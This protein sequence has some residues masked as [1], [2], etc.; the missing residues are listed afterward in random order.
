MSAERALA[1]GQP[2][3]PLCC[4]LTSSHLPWLAGRA[5]WLRP[6]IFQR[7]PCNGRAP[8]GPGIEGAESA[9]QDHWRGAAPVQ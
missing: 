2:P 6:H 1:A 4:K 7:L 3:G 9:I 5:Y 8:E